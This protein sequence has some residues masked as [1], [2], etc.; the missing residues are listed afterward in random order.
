MN[1]KISVVIPVY[2]EEDNLPLLM[3]PLDEVM[4]GINWDAEV[5]S[6]NDGSR[7]NSLQVLKEMQVKYPYIKII[8]LKRNFGQTAA[9]SAG[10]DDSAGSVIITMDADLQNDVLDIPELL[11]EID[12]GFDVVSGWRKVRKDPFLTRRLPSNIA[13]KIISWFTGVKLHDYGCTLKAYRKETVKDLHLYGELHRFIP[14]L[15][16]WSGA[17]IKEIPV[18]HHPRKHGESKYSISRTFNVI[19]DLMTVKF[20]LYRDKGPMRIFGRLGVWSIL[21]GFLSGVVTAGMKLLYSKDMTGNPLLYLSIFLIFV[22]LQF[23]SIGLLG[24]I[25]I[26]TYMEG[27]NKKIYEIKEILTNE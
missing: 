20:L 17:S 25:N 3:T 2:N 9:L 16:S 27:Q 5:I 12:K 6:V 10:F 26:R 21:M 19:L 23:I 15:L 4:K 22:G 24:E 7:D 11:S 8:N 14:A 1:K 13:N 18:K